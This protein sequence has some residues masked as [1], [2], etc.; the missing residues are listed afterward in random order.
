[1]DSLQFQEKISMKIQMNS[2]IEYKP[3]VKKIEVL[4]SI[5]TK[6]NELDILSKDISHKLYWLES[7]LEEYTTFQRDSESY[8]Y[9]QVTDHTR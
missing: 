1:M 7:L 5:L 4:T 3:S 9:F 8:R 2:F 6:W